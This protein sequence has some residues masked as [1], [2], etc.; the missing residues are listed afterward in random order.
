MS[1]VSSTT[2]P[3]A[4]VVTVTL[5]LLKA[6]RADFFRQCVESVHA[7]TYGNIE[8]IVIDGASDDG[9]AD[10]I[11][12]YESRGWLRCISEPD[13]GIYEAMNKGLQHARG[14]YLA[15]LNSD[16]LWHDSRAVELSVSLLEETQASF[17]YAPYTVINEEGQFLSIIEPKL[18]AFISGMPIGHPTMF[19]Q[20][21]LMR[22][23]GG[24]DAENY[25]IIA[26]YDFVTRLLLKGH[27][28]AYVPL[29]FASFRHGGIS[30]QKNDSEEW[31]QEHCALYSKNYSP[32]L[33]IDNE[34][35]LSMHNLPAS[36]LPALASRIHPNLFTQLCQFVHHP[37]GAVPLKL[38]PI[39]N[40]TTKWKG[41]LGIPLLTRISKAGGKHHRWLLFGCIP[42]LSSARSS[43]D[44]SQTCLSTYKLFGLLPVWTHK[45]R[46]GI[47][48]KHYLFGVIPMGGS[49][50]QP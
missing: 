33:G 36:L 35:T 42:L 22:Q 48:Q 1:P 38:A 18:Y 29:N 32:M 40:C 31:Y 39:H 37:A 14:K 41:P 49:K 5:N 24:F 3:V 20:T 10:L 11:A 46:P 26:D 19:C 47:S 43:K 34:L 28:G 50:R 44:G 17:S 4:T 7:Q 27:M 30:L 25:H 21:E 6:G 23:M 12:E 45:S 9:T 16:D 2:A 15:F 13:Q 8:H